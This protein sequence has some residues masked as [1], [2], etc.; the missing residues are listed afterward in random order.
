MEN[1]K[2]NYEKFIPGMAAY[3]GDKDEK[4]TPPKPEVCFYL[5][6]M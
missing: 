2:N 3:Q 1:Y 6:A 5:H 4:N